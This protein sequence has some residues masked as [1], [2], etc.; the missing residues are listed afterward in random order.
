MRQ[1]PL[2]SQEATF[3]G[4]VLTPRFSH[5]PLNN[6]VAVFLTHPSAITHLHSSY[7]KFTPVVQVTSGTGL[8]PEVDAWLIGCVTPNS[9]K[10]TLLSAS[11]FLIRFWAMSD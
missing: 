2:H 10:P 9:T 8:C 5:C 4:K 1:W 11:L 3:S 6:L 7:V